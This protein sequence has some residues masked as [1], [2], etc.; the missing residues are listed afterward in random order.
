MI[1]KILLVSLLAIGLMGSKLNTEKP[2][3]SP[4]ELRKTATHVI[5]GK[6]LAVYERSEIADNWK[7]TRYVAEI[8]ISTIEK[9]QG[10]KTDDLIYARYWR[11]AWQGKGPPPPATGGHRGLPSVGEIIRVYLARNA[12][13]GFGDTNDGG[14]NV[15]GANGFEK[16][17]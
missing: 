7:Y 6:V 14:F 3:M 11:G 13:D 1:R 2:D 9:G 5:T 17:K 15:I 12:Y 4:A 10:L 16:I 8:Q